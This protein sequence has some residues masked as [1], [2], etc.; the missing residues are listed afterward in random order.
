MPRPDRAVDH[1]LRLAD[2]GACVPWDALAAIERAQADAAA[3]RSLAAPD[4]GSRVDRQRWT[5]LRAA[6]GRVRSLGRSPSR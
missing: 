5:S 4:D 6:I 3:R 1:G 2:Q